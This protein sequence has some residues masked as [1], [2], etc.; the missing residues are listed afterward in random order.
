MNSL[1]TERLLGQAD[2]LANANHDL[3]RRLE[4]SPGPTTVATRVKVTQLSA[5]TV[6]SSQSLAAAAMRRA[7]G[8]DPNIVVRASFGGA[9]ADEDG[10][11]VAA[12]KTL[13]LFSRAYQDALYWLLFE[14]VVGKPTS[15]TRGMGVAAEKPTNPVALVLNDRLPKYLPW[16]RGWREVRNEVKEGANLAL[17]GPAEDIGFH[18]TSAQE[19]GS[20]V[21]FDVDRPTIRL[22]TFADALHATADLTLL[23]LALVEE[24]T[25]GAATPKA[26]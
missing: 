10:P 25:G 16:F 6:A 18:F 8:W 15:N 12:A 24:G 5:D 11:P 21:V 14:L 17:V 23:A 3:V 13:L 20:H 4:G 26:R 22:T 7:E 9:L 19:D 1:G 2:D